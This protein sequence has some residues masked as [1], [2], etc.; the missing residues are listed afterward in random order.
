MKVTEN[1]QATQP[2][3]KKVTGTRATAPQLQPNC[4][5]EVAASPEANE[6]GHMVFAIE[7]PNPDLDEKKVEV[8]V[9]VV[10]VQVAAYFF[11][12]SVA[13]QEVTEIQATWVV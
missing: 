3:E 8:V 7:N 4:I 13:S 11:I 9:V 1:V 2:Q 5:I 6:R 12:A 10:L